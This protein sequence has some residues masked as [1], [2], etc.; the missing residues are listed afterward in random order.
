[1]ANDDKPEIPDWVTQPP[2]LTIVPDSALASDDPDADTFDL[3]RQVGPLFEILRHPGTETPFAAA[4]YGDWGT[5]KTSAMR[6]LEGRLDQ[7][8]QWAKTELKND[9]DVR[10]VRTAWFYPWKYHEREEVWRGL[11][12]EVILACLSDE[13]YTLESF[14]RDAKDLGR[15][16]GR[17]VIKVLTSTKVS[18]GVV[19]ADLAALKDIAQDLE[20]TVSPAAAYLNEFE[21]V[22]GAWVESSLAEKERLVVFIDDLDRCMPD[23][24]LQ[25]L[26]ALKLY[27]NIER[28]M[29]VVGVDKTV[30]DQLVVKRYGEMGVD[31]EK[32]RDYLAKMFQVEITLAPTEGEVETFFAGIVARN[33]TWKSLE[34][35]EDA[36][37]PVIID[38][39]KRSPREVKRLVN[40]VLIYATGVRRSKLIAAT[41]VEP[42]TPEQG[43]QD[44]LLRRILGPPPYRMETLI[45]SKTGTA[46]F[47]AWSTA[48]ARDPDE[49]PFLRLSQSEIGALGRARGGDEAHAE[50]AV[51]KRDETAEQEREAV[52]DRVPERFREVVETASFHRYLHLLADRNL[53]ALMHIPYPEEAVVIADLGA[54]DEAKIIR[55][56][57]ARALNIDVEDVTRE[58]YPQVEKIDLAD[59]DIEGVAL[60]ADLKNLKSLD[61]NKTPVRDLAPLAALTSLE[62]LYLHG[63]QLEDLTPLAGLTRLKELNLHSTLVQDLTPLAGLTRLKELNLYATQVHDSA[64]LAALT[65]LEKVSLAGTQVQDLAPLTALTSLEM[66]YLE[67]TQVQDLAP[68][69]AL[70]SLQWLYLE[71][72]QVNDLAPLHGLTNL[73]RVIVTGCPVRREDVDALREALPDAEI[74]FG[75]YEPDEGT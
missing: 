65:N 62:G 24:A 55:E 25:V 2:T 8:N 75:D 66:L 27:L 32:A 39:A 21:K 4:I 20:E 72:A 34:H 60:L 64:P 1:M 47:R 14:T 30:V 61:L 12:A 38:L 22:M 18:V 23:V 13:D 36:L 69:A 28:L 44:F 42:L 56:A 5:G 35:R 74:K 48:V 40:S 37:E 68:L 51:G 67:G 59:S 26:E 10:I 16:L 3:A 41:G 71:G 52:L 73:K 54:P 50:A 6:W 17:S 43:V 31:E 58:D 57:I 7:W 15:F 63:T 9:E 45:G 49:E 46:F 19:E 29:F 11:V 53:G 70:T 33:E